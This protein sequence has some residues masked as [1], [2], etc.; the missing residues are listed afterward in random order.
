MTGMGGSGKTRL[1]IAAGGALLDTHPGG[2]W[3][4]PLAAATRA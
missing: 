3:W 2:V 4:L 1:A